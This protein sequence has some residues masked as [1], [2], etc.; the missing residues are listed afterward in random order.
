MPR[1]MHRK[2][3]IIRTSWENS[4]EFYVRFIEKKINLVHFQNRRHTYTLKYKKNTMHFLKECEIK[5]VYL[6]YS[7]GYEI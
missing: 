2:L 6:K 7:M 3:T 5:Y 1:L 4:L